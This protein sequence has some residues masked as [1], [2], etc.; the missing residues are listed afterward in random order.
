MT[1]TTAL[2][3][4]NRR[5]GPCRRRKPREWRTVLAE[6]LRFAV[7]G[8]VST[9]CYAALSLLFARLWTAPLF[10]LSMLAYALCMPLSFIGH[11]LWSFRSKGPWRQE[12]RRFL[13]LNALGYSVAAISP[14]LLH[15]LGH[16]GEYLSIMVTCVVIPCV[17]FAAMRVFVFRPEAA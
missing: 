8:G 6:S 10:L 2:S 9:L 12:G 15:D 11:R 1:A 14:L 13:A 4:R 16:A 17:N 3:R 7:A 5:V